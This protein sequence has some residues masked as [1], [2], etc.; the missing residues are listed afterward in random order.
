MY[1]VFYPNRIKTVTSE[2]KMITKNKALA[3]FAVLLC[4]NL[5][6]CAYSENDTAYRY[7]DY[8]YEYLG[9]D[10]FESFNRKM[11]NFN[12]KLN[13]YAIKPVHTVWASIMPEY[14]IDRIKSA[15]TNIEYPIR[16][17]STL[18]QKDFK[19]SK[20]ETVRF[21]TNSTLGIGGLFDPADKLFHIEPV[22]EDMEQALAKCKVKQGPYLVLP[23]LSSITPRETAG[24]VLDAAL[25]PSSYIATPV[26]AL[27]KAGLTVNKSY[28]IQPMAKMVE[29][30]YADPYVIAKKFYGVN[31]YI[32][33]ENL[34]RKNVIDQYMKN[35]ENDLLVNNN[36]VN[37][38][39]ENIEDIDSILRVSNETEEKVSLRGN[40]IEPLTV[41]EIIQGSATI[42]NV[43][44][45]S[46][47]NPNSKLFA[48]MLL[49]DFK[50][51][52]PVVDAMRTALF[53]IPGIDDSI[54]TDLSVW[55]RCFNK[56]IRTSSVNITPDR[57][58][59]KYRYIMQKDKNSPLAIIYPSIGEG[60]T[61]HHSVVLAKMFYDAGYSVLIQGSHFQWEFVKSMPKNYRPGLPKQDAQNLQKITGK[62]IGSLQAKY[63]CKF[64]D[65]VLIGTSFGALMTLYIANEEAHNNT[66]NISKFISINPPIELVYAM[67]QIDKNTEEWNKNPENIKEKVAVTAAKIMQVY[68][69]K[70]NL[71]KT[72]VTLPFSDYEGKL[73]TGFLMHQKLSDLIYTL[74]GSSKDI[75]SKIY[76]MG[77]EDYANKYLLSE[78]HESFDELR[79]DTS[80]YAISDYLRENDN[81]KIYHALDDYLVN[82][83]QLRIL[84][85]FSGPKTVIFDHG[86]HLG[87][88]YRQEFINELKKDITLNNK[89]LAQ[90]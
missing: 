79:Y 11:F 55:N 31:N 47:D 64:H 21:L 33:L 17:V 12:L 66:L 23:V 62:I 45:K 13:K 54:W 8:A 30:N 38:D 4:M 84:K 42:D 15:T 76:N 83:Q 90:N 16:L 43:I 19:A 70:E 67:K 40:E 65:N 39:E 71:D 32:K 57:Q 29:S 2:D 41:N 73:I 6:N 28:A 77:Y 69:N 18:L 50:P 10:K 27:V 81:Y 20:T 24:K 56:K 78:Q 9:N 72:N 52:S 26:I 5:Y 82:K 58:N 36:E 35:F 3:V 86:S 68:N 85:K 7:P 88:L 49:F 60:I 51:Q 59:Y 37:N 74:E 87:F 89:T 61:S 25:N 75:Y 14:G 22:A 1:F 53:D 46:Y 80:L 34:D 44:M 48:D 63:D